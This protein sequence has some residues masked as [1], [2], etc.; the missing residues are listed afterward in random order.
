MSAD[1][2]L[3]F[4]QQYGRVITPQEDI[5]THIQTGAGE[6]RALTN[7]LLGLAICLF[8]ADVA[9]RR[10]QYVPRWRFAKR[11]RKKA[12]P[13]GEPGAQEVQRT[14]TQLGDGQGIGSLP[15]DGQDSAA[16]A[17]QS[18]GERPTADK[19]APENEK[20]P[21]KDKNSKKE[22]KAKVSEQTLDTSQLL[23]KKDNRNI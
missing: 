17:M 20:K 3:S 10:F 14:T 18:A 4:V 15:H 12:D 11:T 21:K 8:L 13:A 19:Q 22:K 2:Y 7:W 9:M 23:K 16:S 6:K 1:P 5:W